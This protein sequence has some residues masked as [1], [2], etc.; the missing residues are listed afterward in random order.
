MFPAPFAAL[1]DACVLY[2]FT[3]RDTLLRCAERDLYQLYWSDPILREATRNLVKNGLMDDDKAERLAQQM[4]DAFPA[5]MVDDFEDLI[6]AMHNHEKDR[7]VAAAAVKAGAKVIVSF[8]VKDF[9]N[10]P[11][12]YEVQSPDEFLCHQYDLNPDA[13]VSIIKEQAEDL[14][15]PPHTPEEIASA[16]SLLVPRF[17]KTIL[18]ALGASASP[19]I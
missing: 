5:A 19:S 15:N 2:P 12:G 7:H 10:L 16:L 6:L 13:L 11:S 3:L 9:K 1:L 14:R 18:A 17:G 4:C 8:N